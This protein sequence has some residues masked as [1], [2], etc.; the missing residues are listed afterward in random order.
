MP[1]L[2]D[3][4]IIGASGVLMWGS[5]NSEVHIKRT[6]SETWGTKA[7]DER[8]VVGN[9][10]S[11]LV[12]MK[13]SILGPLVRNGSSELKFRLGGVLVRNVELWAGG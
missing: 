3:R 9:L 1:G 12:T 11:D 10:V 8:S 5:G 4:V 6:E 2:R 13:R 7:Q